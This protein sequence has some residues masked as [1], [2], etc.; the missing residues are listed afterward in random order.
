MTLA[1]IGLLPPGM[2]APAAA[3][4]ASVPLMFGVL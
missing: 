2:I 1:A 3:A 4:P